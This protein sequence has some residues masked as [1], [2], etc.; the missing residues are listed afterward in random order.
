MAQPAFQGANFA[1]RLHKYATQL[2]LTVA[3]EHESSV[4]RPDGKP[5]ARSGAVQLRLDQLEEDWHGGVEKIA[6]KSHP[7]TVVDQ[8][9]REE[10]Q[11][12]GC[13]VL[14]EWEDEE[15]ESWWDDEEE[16]GE[17]EEMEWTDRFSAHK[18]LTEPSFSAD[19][20]PAWAPN[21][22]E[23]VMISIKP[24]HKRLMRELA[25]PSEGYSGSARTV[26][27]VWR[28][29]RRRGEQSQYSHAFWRMDYQQMR[30]LEESSGLTARRDG[31]YNETY[32]NP[33]FPNDPPTQSHLL[34]DV[35]FQQLDA[36]P[37]RGNW[38]E[39]RGH[40]ATASADEQLKFFDFIEDAARVL[41]PKCRPKL[42]RCMTIA[43]PDNPIFNL[44][45]RVE[46]WFG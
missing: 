41:P 21:R 35:V 29:Q 46:G 9:E 34:N 2:G 4:I 27:E 1:D 18:H 15:F 26:V 44:A 37:K 42:S 28:R 8:I 33:Y 39:C 32:P 12:Q 24:Q 10:K 14:K 11:Y 31:A 5:S 43:T 6:L 40:L 38:S 16:E 45:K 20:G 13:Q 17:E 7:K 23:P 3:L 25:K 22:A 36:H 30:A 19:T